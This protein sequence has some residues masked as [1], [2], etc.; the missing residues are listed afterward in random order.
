[1]IVEKVMP[2]PAGSIVVETPQLG[3]IAVQKIAELTPGQLTKAIAAPLPI[4][5]SLY[6]FFNENGVLAPF[7][8]DSMGASNAVA[9]YRIFYTTRI[10][11]TSA[12]ADVTGLLAV[13]C[14]SGQAS[15]P[16]VSWQ[17]GTIFEPEDAPSMLFEDDGRI[18][19]DAHGI[20]R[21]A[22]TLFNV[23]Q[24]A[25]NGYV[26]AA[27]DYVG[28]AQSPGR[29]AYA[30]KE[31]TVQTLRDMLIASRA[32]LGQLG[33][34]TRGLCLYGWSQG[35]LNTQWL[36]SALQQ[37]SEFAPLRVA[38]VSAPTD[39]AQL[40]RYWMNDYPGEPAWL[41]GAMPVLFGAYETYYGEAEGLGNLMAEAIRPQYLEIA[42]KIADK[43]YDW[44][45]VSW[46]DPRPIC[47]PNNDAVPRMCLPVRPVEMLNRDFLLEFNAR[48]GPF[49][50]RLRANS[51]LQDRYAMPSRFYGGASDA[52]VP[53]WCSM[54]LP[55]EH[56]Q[57]LGNTRIQ[58]VPPELGL[59]QSPANAGIGATHRSAFLAS[60]FAPG[61]GVRHWFDAALA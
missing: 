14:L 38:A 51:A 11:E 47:D 15:L 13:P 27:A 18:R 49:Y 12:S 45:G 40:C 7:N 35:G 58:P 57:A 37:D 6:D 4:G 56:Q 20:P 17:H 29:Q 55:T 32:A 26:V 46:S 39:L 9:F 33:L 42:R 52:V 19:C 34:E 36:A 21:S 44:P 30:L 60:L 59:I 25:G 3:T 5:I 43:A 8:A 31:A 22:E 28:N 50:A 2:F 41:T 1:M 61:I 16:M 48:R 23:V 53:R 54:L 10:P 24:L